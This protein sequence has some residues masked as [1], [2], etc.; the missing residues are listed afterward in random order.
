LI[1]HEETGLLVPPEDDEAMGAA[2]LRMLTDAELR[3]RVIPAA[4]KK[5]EQ[6]FDNRVLIRK[7]GEIYKSF[8]I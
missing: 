7:L 2:M 1:T 5:V 4:R 3:A 8:G 6:D